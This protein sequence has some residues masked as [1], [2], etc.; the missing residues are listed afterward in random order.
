MSKI[1]AQGEGTGYEA[2]A[3]MGF[4]FLSEGE[5]GGTWTRRQ[6]LSLN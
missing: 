1:L 4:Y 6:G 3:E 5:P 2:V